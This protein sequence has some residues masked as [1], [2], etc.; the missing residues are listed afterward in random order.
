MRATVRGIL[1]PY[2]E[3]TTGGENAS[4]RARSVGEEH[5]DG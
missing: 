2:A 3:R 5:P 4:S 1:R